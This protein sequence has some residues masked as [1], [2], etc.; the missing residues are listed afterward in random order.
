MLR[1]ATLF[2][3][4]VL[5]GGPVGA[6][7][8]E[9]WCVSPAGRN[10]QQRAG[11]HDGSSPIDTPQVESG[12][13]CHAI[14]ATVPFLAEGRRSAPAS[15]ATSGAMPHLTASGTRDGRSGKRPDDLR[16]VAPGDPP[17]HDVLR[18]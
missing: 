14:A 9:T 10:H 11:C 18:I 13:G 17:S 3:V 12:E 6:L 8:C 7:L 1:A 16:R 15:V 4:L 2:I 5:G